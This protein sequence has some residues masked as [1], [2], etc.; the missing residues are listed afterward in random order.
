LTRRIR[1]LGFGWAW[2][3]AA[4]WLIRHPPDLELVRQEVQGIREHWAGWQPGAMAA[5][6]LVTLRAL[7]VVVCMAAA[8]RQAG[9]M[10]LAL[11]NEGIN[12]DCISSSEMTV[13]CVIASDQVDRGV[14]AVHHEFF[15]SQR[16]KTPA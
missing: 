14:R 2:G 6:H 4:L 3:V 10:F 9:R 8:C 15:S 13:S 16:V 7:G 5:R 12:V 11:A 1:L